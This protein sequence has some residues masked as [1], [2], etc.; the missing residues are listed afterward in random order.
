MRIA[1]PI[2][3]VIFKYLMENMEIAKDI[4]SAILGETIVS[5]EMKPQELVTQSE[6]GVKVARMDFKAVI[7]HQSGELKTTLI[8]LEKNKRGLEVPRFRR[9]L[10][11][12]YSKPTMVSTETGISEQYDLPITVIYFLGYELNK[13]IDAAVL[14][15]ERIY[16]NVVT[17]TIFTLKD[18]FIEALS[19]DLYVIQIPKLAMVA[20]TELEQLLDVFNVSKYK[21]N[22]SHILEYTGVTTNPKVQRVVKYLNK[23]MQV[24]DIIEAMQVEDEIDHLI[25]GYKKVTED[26]KRE[27]DEAVLQKDEAVLQK[28]EAV[29]QK[30][31]AIHQ[32]DEAIRQTKEVIHQKEEAIRQT[33]EVIHQKDEAIRQLNLVEQQAEEE[34]R[35]KEEAL[36]QIERLKQ[37][38]EE[39]KKAGK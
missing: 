10:G 11:S 31:E 21:T 5:L 35:Q 29:L 30:D 13:D 9:Y 14:K 34:R 36:L 3:D 28:D 38:L 15:V 20:Q 7:R 37:Q 6:G 22:D 12:N 39:M 2:Y 18:T 1:N 19:H 17:N 25:D 24:D 16:R 32:K 4:I 8:E 33:K 26:A 27:K 23:A